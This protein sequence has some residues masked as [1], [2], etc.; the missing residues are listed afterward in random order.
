VVVARSRQVA[1]RANWLA[2]GS[3]FD[4]DIDRSLGFWVEPPWSS[5]NKGLVPLNVIEDS[6]KLHPAVTPGRRFVSKTI[7]TESPAGCIT[8]TPYYLRHTGDA[9]PEDRTL[10]Y[11]PYAMPNLEVQLDNIGPLG[12]SSYST[13]LLA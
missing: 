13:S 2:V 5:V 11:N 10:R 8:F 4:R 12:F 6:F 9:W 7:F 1:P 3:R